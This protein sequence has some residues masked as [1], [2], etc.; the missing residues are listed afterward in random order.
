MKNKGIASEYIPWLVIGISVLVIV[1]ISVFLLKNQGLSL[2][3]K[4]KNIFK[5]G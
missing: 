5:F 1:L 4:I 3:D 2:I